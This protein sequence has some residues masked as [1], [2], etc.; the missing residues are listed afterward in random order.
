[1]KQQLKFL[2][3][4]IGILVLVAFVLFVFNQV[5]QVYVYTNAINPILGKSVLAALTLLFAALFIMPVVLYFRLP[6]PIT[7]PETAEE[8]T[9]YLGRLGKR[10]SRNPL[11]RN[12]ILDF[13]REE[14]IQKGLDL[15]SNRADLVIQNTA[16]SIFLTTAISQNGKLDA[17]T[18]FITQSKMVWDLAHIYYQRPAPKD[19][20][21]LYANVGAATFLAAQIEDL[22]FSEQLEPVFG[23][24]LQNSALRSVP[25]VSSVTNVVMDSLL[26]GTINAF[27]T[28]RVGI[29]TKRYCGTLDTFNVRKVRRAAFREASGMLKT[30]VVQSSG[31]VVSGIMR[32][33]K[34]AG[35]DT[36][37][38]GVGAA[39]RA[40][41]RVKSGLR[42]LAGKVRNIP[43]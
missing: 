18:V 22:D 37:K 15:L 23:T 20:V 39:E 36:V 12:E 34:K 35:A 33:T 14:D 5:T 7:P 11:L 31:Q 19:I 24:V 43:E 16:K 28:L 1:M 4:T 3:L 9:P 21:A 32:A 26:E 41:G 8:R 2:F 29:V 10:L 6:T 42:S 13:S 40:S 38:S 27:L 30:I 17:L 25:F